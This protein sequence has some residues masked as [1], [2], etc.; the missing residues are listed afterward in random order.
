MR[1]VFTGSRG[2]G[3]NRFLML[4]RGVPTVTG[5]Y[6]ATK[7]FG[8]SVLAAFLAE[9]GFWVYIIA[10]KKNYAYLIYMFFIIINSYSEFY[11]FRGNGLFATVIFMCMLNQEY[12]EVHRVE[13]ADKFIRSITHL[14]RE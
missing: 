9:R 12:K 5:A 6:Q 7:M 8:G 14:K 11:W 2:S 3:I 13:K 4:Y 1:Y 10:Y